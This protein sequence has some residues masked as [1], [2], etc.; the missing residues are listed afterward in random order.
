MRQAFTKGRGA[1][2]ADLTDDV[3]L[4]GAARFNVRKGARATIFLEM[5]GDPEDGGD[6]QGCV[7]ASNL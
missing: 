6:L 4:S 3:V 5:Q 1:G 7:V 2:T